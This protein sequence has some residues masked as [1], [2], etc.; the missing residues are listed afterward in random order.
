V[1]ARSDNREWQLFGWQ[2]LAFNAPRD[3]SLAAVY[4]DWKNGYACM[5]D[6][7][8][9]RLEVRWERAGRPVQW[10]S[11][12]NK[13]LD[14]LKKKS[15]KIGLTLDSRNLSLSPAKPYEAKG[16]EW[17]NNNA[18]HAVAG[19]RCPEC[20]RLALFQVIGLP[21]ENGA[22]L[23][24]KMIASFHDHRDDG[25][26]V[27][28]FFDMRADL[29]DSFELM[30]AGFKAGLIELKFREARAEF[31]FRRLALGKRTLGGVGLKDWALK[32]HGKD[33]ARCSWSSRSFVQAGHDGIQLLGKPRRIRIF[34]RKRRAV[35]CWLCGESDR[36]FFLTFTGGSDPLARLNELLGGFTCHS[37]GESFGPKKEAE[38]RTEPES[39]SSD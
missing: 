27:W 26:K 7:D 10:E 35:V 18:T 37:D 19:I 34:D 5:D 13:Y 32:F 33:A 30:Q 8:R 22:K 6:P 31:S 12:F 29:P 24:A 15:R 3:W 17:K 28:S 38:S 1:K 16:V 20:R 9:V 4:G 36:L 2:G 23:L 25:N 39:Q 11:T 14:K 21:R